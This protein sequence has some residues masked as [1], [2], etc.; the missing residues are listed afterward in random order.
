M[1]PRHLLLMLP[2][3]LTT[4]RPP[5]PT[6]I[7]T[8]TPGDGSGT[9]AKP[10]AAG[11]LGALSEGSKLHGFTATTLY[12][13]DADQP[14]G[15]RFVHDATKF[16][17]DYLRVETAPQGFIWVTS[18]PTSDKGEPHTQEHLLLGKGD[19]GRKLGSSE[20]MALAESSAFTAQW[21][22]AYHFHTVAGHDVFWPVFENHLDAM[23]N[24]DYTDEEI[25]REVRNFGVDKDDAGKLRLEEKGTVYN[26]MV[27][28][29]ENPDVGMWRAIGQLV[30]GATHPLALDSGGH[31]D[32][33]RTMTPADIRA[34]HKDAYHL[35]N[36]GMIAAYP[37]SM[38]LASV[39]E[40]ADKILD[41]AKAK[42]GH[43]GKLSAEADLPK[44]TGASSGTT[45]I[46][47]YP[48]ADA[49][50]PGPMMFAWPATRKLDDAERVLLGLFLDAFAG[51]ESTV[52][53]KKLIDSKTRV[54]DLGA[55]SVWAYN[56][57]DQGHPVFIGVTGAKPDKLDD[58][59][60]GEVRALMLAEL[61]RIAQLPDGAADLTAFNAKVSSRVV[62]LQRRLNKFLDSPPGFGSRGT[63]SGWMD[64]LQSLSKT[65]GFKKS[66]TLRPALV[67]V[68]ETLVGKTNPWRDRLRTWGLLDTPYAVAA[69][70]SPEYRKK[71][72]AERKTRIDAELA[73]LQTQFGTKDAAATLARYQQDYDAETKR[74]EAAAAATELPALVSS[75]PMTLDDGL[76]YTT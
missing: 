38:S 68:R 20:A 42:N 14:L 47:E 37:S 35:A 2:F 24:P 19:R 4:C 70:P 18:F 21:R 40:H 56:T 36:M 48:Y 65:G 7:T 71:L 54:L 61:S 9:V 44:P 66:L 27:R 67:K 23:V 69:K 52:L 28:T 72:D 16:T 76:Q 17:L 22:T 26:E 29:Y 6:K 33:I 75:L 64:H 55:N 59:T 58:K 45:K 62:D 51:D 39:L 53:Y 57:D 11:E 73:R 31:P 5:E 3:T 60:L 63:S 43:V 25:R 41:D 30:F 13:D 50:N 46:I 32:A 8:P 34:F 74:L 49:T 15:G 10:P 12:L 1:H